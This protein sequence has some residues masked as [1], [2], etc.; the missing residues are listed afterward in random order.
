MSKPE[1]GAY[2]E[3]RSIMCSIICGIERLVEVLNYL[4][5]ST[6]IGPKISPRPKNGPILQEF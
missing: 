3:H 5:N 1:N 6:A 2:I 4:R